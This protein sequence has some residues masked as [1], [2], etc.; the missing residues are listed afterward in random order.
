MFSVCLFHCLNL[1]TERVQRKQKKLGA[2]VQ[3]FSGRGGGGG[4]G[5]G[6]GQGSTLIFSS[7][8]GETGAK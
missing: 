6:G 4:G 5:G 7:N 1:F 2:G 3:A 8:V